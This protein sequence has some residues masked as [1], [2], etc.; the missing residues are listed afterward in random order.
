VSGAR[1]GEHFHVLFNVVK[2]NMV[3]MKCVIVFLFVA[4]FGSDAA[5]SAQIAWNH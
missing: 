1:A 4:S 3:Q 2:K 5:S